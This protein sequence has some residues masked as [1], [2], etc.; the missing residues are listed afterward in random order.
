VIQMLEREME[1]LLAKYPEEFFPRHKFTLEGR[2][3]S[4]AG[5]GRFDLLFRDHH[6][7]LNLMELKARTLKYEDASQVAGYFDE[8]HARGHKNV[9]MWLIAPHIPQSVR[10]FLDDKGI[11]YEEIHFSQFKTVARHHGYAIASESQD[12]QQAKREQTT[13]KPLKAKKIRAARVSPVSSV[14]VG[15]E[16]TEPSPLRWRAFGYDLQL[17]T[18]ELLDLSRFGTLLDEFE[19]ASGKKSASVVRDLRDWIAAPEK[20]VLPAITIRTLLRWTT[21][22]GPSYKAAVPSAEALWRFLF[23]APAPAWYWWEQA[24]REY[25]FDPEAWK[26][27]FESLNRVPERLERIF[28]EHNTDKPHADPAM[29][30][31]CADCKAYRSYMHAFGTRA[32]HP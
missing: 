8:L 32:A 4:F 7:W 11:Q 19:T 5:V 17:L 1:D 3:K 28:R 13:T 20:N 16:V 18:P 27:W 30:C 6:H 21:T 2:Q 23:G 10:L 12:V 31:Q 25:N 29:Q 9:V 14:A 15:P 22:N 26:Q 24:E